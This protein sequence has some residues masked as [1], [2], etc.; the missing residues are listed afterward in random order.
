MQKLKSLLQEKEAV[1]DAVSVAA[2]Y[3]EEA[4]GELSLLS[5]ADPEIKGLLIAFADQILSPL[6][7]KLP[8]V[9]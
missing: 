4:K 3:I 9:G 6:K 1:E 7:E 5:Q 8:A 2:N